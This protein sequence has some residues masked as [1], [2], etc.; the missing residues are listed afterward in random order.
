MFAALD[1][2]ARIVPSDRIQAVM[3][4]RTLF[5]VVTG[6]TPVPGEDCDL[7][8]VWEGAVSP[9]VAEAIAMMCRG[10]FSDMSSALRFLQ[11]NATRRVVRPVKSGRKPA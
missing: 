7:D 11:R 6:T 4:G 8:R 9:P 5:E 1:S 2:G 3:A 10:N